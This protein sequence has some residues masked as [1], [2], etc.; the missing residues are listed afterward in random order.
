[1]AQAEI[2][3]STLNVLAGRLDELESELD[4]TDRA[5]LWGVFSLAAEEAAAPAEEG[6]GNSH[7]VDVRPY[8]SLTQVIDGAFTPGA[9]ESVRT[10]K[11]VISNDPDDPDDDGGGD[12]D[13]DGD[14][15]GDSGDQ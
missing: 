15:G 13:G 9:W 2:S 1:M 6:R 8:A 5:L 12:G 4:G 11:L 3:Q 7:P 14:G 10:P